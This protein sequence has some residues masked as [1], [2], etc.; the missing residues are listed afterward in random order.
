MKIIISVDP[1]MTN[2]GFCVAKVNDDNTLKIEYCKTFDFTNKES[3]AEFYYSGILWLRSYADDIIALPYEYNPFGNNI[4]QRGQHRAVGFIQG[5]IFAE[6]LKFPVV[7]INSSHVKAVFG[8][9]RATKEET[10]AKVKARYGIECDE[11]SADAISIAY[12]YWQDYQEKERIKQ[13]KKQQKK[14]KLL[15]TRDKK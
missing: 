11:H 12:C 15:K 1:S 6:G 3:S 7:A 2:M 5:L 8:N 10:I 13:V 4:I 9:G 14:L